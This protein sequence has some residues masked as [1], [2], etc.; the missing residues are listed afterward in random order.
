MSANCVY[1]WS[2][3]LPLA[4]TDPTTPA[5]GDPVIFGQLP[6]VALTAEDSAGNTTVALNG[7]F[8]LS[9][10]GTSGSNAAI[11]A[12][13]KI[14]YVSANTPKLSVTTSGVFYGYAL[15]NVSS[16]ATSTIKVKVGS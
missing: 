5:S 15:E 12:G 8:N 6:G 1:K 13:D 7:T 2:Q 14:Y 9:V 10:K 4:C 3:S 11:T 16:G